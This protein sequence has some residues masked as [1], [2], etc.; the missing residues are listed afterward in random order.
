MIQTHAAMLELT[1]RHRHMPQHCSCWEYHSFNQPIQHRSCL[2][3]TSTFAYQQSVWKVCCGKMAEW[4]Q[5]LLGVVSGVGWGMGILDGNPHAS[6]ERCVFLGFSPPL[7][8]MVYFK[9][10]MYSTRARK[11]DNISVQ[12]MYCWN[13]H[14]IGF[15]KI[16]LSSR[17]L[18]G[19]TRNMQ[20]CNSHLR[21]KSSQS[22]NAAARFYGRL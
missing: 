8:W 6:R 21:H 19:F 10:E 18:L 5:M 12:T 22:S 3:L 13:L 14:F 20:K 7:V 2:Q 4:I 9:T 1:H 11:V 15:P 17:S 16:Q